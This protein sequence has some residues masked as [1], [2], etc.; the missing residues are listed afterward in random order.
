MINL[1]AEKDQLIV[2]SIR[3]EE[4]SFS[5]ESKI[6]FSLFHSQG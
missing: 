6:Q 1:F 4:N 3:E 5:K 2:E